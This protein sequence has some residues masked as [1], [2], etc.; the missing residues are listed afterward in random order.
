[1]PKPS[2]ANPSP[3]YIHAPLG[4]DEGATSTAQLHMLCHQLNR[5]GYP[6]YLAAAPTVYGN[7]WTPILTPQTM[8]AHQM[9]GVIPISIQLRAGG[10]PV[11][12]G[13]QVRFE[14]ALQDGVSSDAHARLHFSVLGALA[15]T[16]ESYTLTAALPWFDTALL[17][18]APGAV[19]RKGS[20]VYSGHLPGPQFMLRPEH[21][22]LP[23]VSPFAQQPMGVQ[24]RW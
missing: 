16:T 13:V 14:P 15:N 8:A 9:V 1:M 6:A 11:L 5:A 24:E 18:H 3:Y 22:V 20:L 4:L 7:W 23:D 19:Q 2:P 21:S 12:P 17:D 10:D